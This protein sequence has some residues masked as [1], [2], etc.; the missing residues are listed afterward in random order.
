M[1]AAAPASSRSAPRNAKGVRPVDRLGH[2]GELREVERAQARH[3]LR[4]VA[5]ELRTHV[6][7]PRAHDLDLAVEIRVIDPVVE[8]PALQRVVQLAGPVRRDH[9]GRRR[10]RLDLADL[11]DRDRE[12]R[13]DLQQEGLELVVGPVELVDEQHGV[14][15]RRGSPRAAAA[16]PGTPARTGPRRA[17]RHR[18]RRAP[19]RRSAGARSS[20]RRGPATRRSPRST[21]ERISR[22]PSS[23]PS[24]FATSVLPTPASPSSS[25]GLW[26]DSD[27]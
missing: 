9:D 5:R 15:P 22:R 8:A 18:R 23:S 24:T 17:A 16:R 11:G 13:E 12:L 25:S 10:E 19:A 21:A 3:R 6:R 7:R 1:S 26:S 2:A 14:A 4:D 20:T 27:R